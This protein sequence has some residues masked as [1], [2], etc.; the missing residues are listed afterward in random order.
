MRKK[1]VDF[2]AS[3]FYSGY[4]PWASGTAGSAVAVVLATLLYAAIPEAAGTQGSLIAA[5]LWTAVAIVVTNLALELALYSNRAHDPRQIVIDEIAGYFV[6][7]VALPK[8]PLTL[9]VAFLAFRIFDVW[10]PFPI[11]RVEKLP[12]GYGIVLDDVLAGVYAGVAVH[13]ML[14]LA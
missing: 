8:D 13:I 14:F 9:V 3:G 5:V 1:V 4:S 6:T 11:R 12:R 7:V 2:L 10:K